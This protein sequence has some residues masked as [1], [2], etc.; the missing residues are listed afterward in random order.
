MPV[1][2]GRT[3]QLRHFLVWLQVYLVSGDFA[4]KEGWVCCNVPRATYD[5][6]TEMARQRRGGDEVRG[7]AALS[8]AIG[9][10]VVLTTW[11]NVGA[12][13]FGWSGYRA[14]IEQAAKRYG[15]DTALIRALIKVESDFTPDAVSSAG[16]VGSMQV[17][18]QSASD[19]GVDE[20]QALF[21]AATNITVGTRHLKRLLLKYRNISRALS[22][23][24]A[25]EGNGQQFR[26]VGVFVETRKYTVR[27][28]K[29]FQQYRQQ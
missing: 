23:Y 1:I 2:V 14:M 24:H 8:A 13:A 20:R 26:R 28:I 22:A 17:L 15:V 19:Y 3:P 11:L 6:M 25:G 27:V 9:L 12:A 29:Y 4:D 18:P 21:D 5:G 7:R 10:S 16:A